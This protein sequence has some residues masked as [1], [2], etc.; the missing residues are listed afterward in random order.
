M[1]S[2]TAPVASA[3]AKSPDK[4]YTKISVTKFNATQIVLYDNFNSVS[5]YNFSEFSLY[6]GLPFSL[7]CVVFNTP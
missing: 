7:L 3:V 6:S 4:I 5:R 2:I 1:N